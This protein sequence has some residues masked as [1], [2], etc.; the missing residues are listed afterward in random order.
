MKCLVHYDQW[1]VLGDWL[2]SDS[3]RL[4]TSDSCSHYILLFEESITDLQCVH[5]QIEGD[6][7]NLVS[8]SG[9]QGKF[10]STRIHWIGFG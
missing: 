2:G 7:T 6:E 9:N 3:G 1:L 8:R 4:L 5:R 10:W